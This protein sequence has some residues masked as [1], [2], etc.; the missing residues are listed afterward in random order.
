MGVIG[1]V[2]LNKMVMA[3]AVAFAATFMASQWVL[4]ENTLVIFILKAL[5]FWGTY[6]VIL[7]MLKDEFTMSIV[8]PLYRKLIRRKR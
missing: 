1:K 7:V 5:I 6:I 4:A 2:H 8:E 3:D